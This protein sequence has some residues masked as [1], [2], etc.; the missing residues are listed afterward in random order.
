MRCDLHAHSKHSG[1]VD[2]PVLRRLAREC[3]SEP[4]AVY[5]TALQRG[6]DLVTL[7]DHDT[8]EGALTLA[9]LP[10]F[11]VGEEVTC[12][13]PGGRSLHVGVYDITPAQHETI[14]RR[15]TDAEA[16]F[17]YLAEQ[18]IPAV[19]NHL[20]SPLTGARD[21]ADFHLALRGVRL[22]E[23]RNGMMPESTNL[24]ALRAAKS[25]GRATVGGSDAH[26][27]ATVARAWTIVPGARSKEGFIEGL[28]RGATIA[29]GRSGSY[30]RLTAD[31]LRLFAG[32]GADLARSVS[33]GPVAAVRWAALLAAAPFAGLV[34]VAA[35]A[36]YW[37]DTWRAA[38]LYRRFTASARPPK[39]RSGFAG[40]L[41]LPRPS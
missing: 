8:I 39:G 2:L 1:P 9:H 27:L 32:T 37:S 41:V 14:A 29:A 35:L 7:T 40:S 6:M 13:L 4:L 16:L 22:V 17:A 34:P 3:Y 38:A 18:R 33:G 11:I 30:A 21:V 24:A 10:R 31:L 5:E 20:F 12:T 15:R 23:A 28:R 36:S 19:V 26:T 25:A